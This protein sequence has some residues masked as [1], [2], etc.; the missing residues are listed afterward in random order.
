MSDL[1]VIV[2]MKDKL[3]TPPVQKGER[4][5]KGDR[6]DSGQRGP[7]GADVSLNKIIFMKI[8]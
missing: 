3:Q 1:K 8:Q 2:D 5:D 6:G 7:A 4:G